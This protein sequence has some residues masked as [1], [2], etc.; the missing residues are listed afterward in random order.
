MCP[1]CEFLN[2]KNDG[3]FSRCF[4]RFL[5]NKCFE[6]GCVVRTLYLLD[7]KKYHE[8]YIDQLKE[9]VIEARTREL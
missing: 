8:D 2:C 5:C 1:K 6:F 4:N 7:N 3:I 9:L